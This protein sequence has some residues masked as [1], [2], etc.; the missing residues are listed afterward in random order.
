VDHA[1]ATY[2]GRLAANVKD[3]IVRGTNLAGKQACRLLYTGQSA[4]AVIGTT[5][6]QYGAS[7]D[8]AV[9]L[10]NAARSTMCTQA[11]G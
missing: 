2:R 5:A 6:A 3:G 1:F 4:S 10:V 8:Q 9:G 7:A 11:L